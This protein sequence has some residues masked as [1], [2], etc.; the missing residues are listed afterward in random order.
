MQTHI[1]PEYS[2]SA[3]GKEADSIL[4]NCVH[5]GFCTATCP[6]YQL[7]GDE[8]DG[9]RGRIYLIKQVLE[10]E[11]ISRRTQLHL[12]R[13]L[14]C[15]SCETTC[16]SGVR[17]GQLLEA[18]QAIVNAKVKR[19]LGHRILRKA[20]RMTLPYPG[21]FGLL[22]QGARLVKPLL[23][24]RLRNKIPNSTPAPAP[25]KTQHPRKVILFT[26]CVQSVVAANINQAAQRVL[27]K[28]GIEAVVVAGEKCCGAV[29]HHLDDIATAQQFAATNLALWSPLLETE[30]EAVVSTASA[31]ALELRD[32]AHLLED[33]PETGSG[34]RLLEQRCFDIG[35]FIAREAA[36]KLKISDQAPT[37]AYHAPCTL[38]HGLKQSDVVLKLLDELGFSI[39]EPQDAH[40]CCGSAGTYSITQPDI[41]SQLQKNKCRAL[42][43]L[44][45]GL[46]VTANI[47]CML[48]LQAETEL[49]VRHWIEVLD[50]YLV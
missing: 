21:R 49:E 17:Y 31:C 15:R 47:G 43:A 44:Q 48:H 3:L 4:R 27:D 38:K 20:M 34:A 40:L 45:P 2:D 33:R 50:Q 19:P 14:L 26:G 42:E 7:L 13:C 6:T 11:Q 28:L 36:G 9:P 5:C 22:L 35:E 25:Q 10:G 30:A 37:L 16:P 8:L 29:N 41:S 1:A 12:D 39:T 32:Y 24:S 18:G 46:I 23:P